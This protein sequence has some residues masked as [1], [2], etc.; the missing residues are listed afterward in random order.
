VI[1]VVPVRAGEVARGG[2]E[3]VAQ[4]GGRVILVGDDPGAAVDAMRDVATHVRVA[5][6]V[7]FAPDRWAAGLTPLVEHEDV[8]VLPASADGRDLA[9]RLAHRLGRP[10]LAGAVEVRAGGAVLA[11]RGGLVM[12]EV[13]VDGPFVA[14]LDPGGAGTGALSPPSAARAGPPVIE[15]IS[16][17]GDGAD[18]VPL[19]VLAADPATVDLS[20]A[21][22]VVAA[23]AGLGSAAMVA[24][25]GT[26]ATALGASLG[27][28]RVVTDLGWAPVERQIGTTG[29]TVDPDLY[30]AVGI[31]GAVQHVSGIGQPA[32]VVAVNTDPSCPMMALADLAVVT[33]GPAFV[34]ALAAILLR[35]G[36]SGSGGLVS[37]PDPVSS[38]GLVGSGG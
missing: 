31:S 29:V 30:V 32:H 6:E 5:D 23:G 12:D 27:A 25:L 2:P 22:R 37:S 21:T 7:G 11:R 19:A 8:V 4:A 17:A 9:P 16:L 35:S 28:T 15:P 18:P 10:L 13:T 38:T 1:A 14:T 36:L 34:E 26:V 20:E 33:D 24:A 3:A